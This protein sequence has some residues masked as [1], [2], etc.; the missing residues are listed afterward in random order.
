MIADSEDEAIAAWK[1]RTPSVNYIA[2][3][4]THPT[5]VTF[6]DGRVVS[7]K[8]GGYLDVSRC[9]SAPSEPTP[10]SSGDRAEAAIAKAG[11]PVKALDT[12]RQ[13]RAHFNVEYPISKGG[14]PSVGYDSE[15]LPKVIAL[16]DA[17]LAAPADSAEPVPGMVL[18]EG[19]LSMHGKCVVI[20]YEDR[21]DADR[22]FDI[23]ESL[24]AP[25]LSNG[26]RG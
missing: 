23:L 24:L 13:V 4:E 25:A 6:S 7:I 26:E 3:D 8:S 14:R 11:E 9:E 17:A 5:R 20:D 1:R 12:I 2:D 18:P 19:T 22:A 10:S 16:L 15:A 21:V